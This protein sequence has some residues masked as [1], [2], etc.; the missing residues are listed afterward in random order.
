MRLSPIAH[1]PDD[2]R[3]PL[4]A[5]QIGAICERA[6]GGSATVESADELDGGEFNATYRL[7]LAGREVPAGSPPA[8]VILRAAPTPA[9]DLAWHEVA[10]MRRELAVAPFFAPVAARMPRTLYSDLTHQIVPRDYVLQSV[11]PGVC[12]RDLRATLPAEE[13]EALWREL[14]GIA[15]TIHSVEGDA[16]GMPVSGGSYPTWS[17]AIIAWLDLT[18][19]DLARAGCDTALVLALRE[20]AAERAELL[21]EVR[22]PRL[23]HG[24]LW[25]FN[26]LIERG[27]DGADG[28]DSWDS[29]DG[30]HISAVLDADRATWGDPLY[31][32]TFHLLPRKASERV[33]SVFWEAYGRP[34][35][36]PGLRFRERLY[37]ALHTANV[38][39]EVARRGRG[40]Q[41]VE[42]AAALRTTAERALA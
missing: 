32:W 11:M 16:F 36:T 2:L 33:R 39:A 23:L 15:R 22:V 31:E 42:I 7:H 26:V 29:A 8:S 6:F 25:P 38:L 37:D 14:A 1:G 21:D 18:A 13:D 3:E 17:A 9:R 30:P 41:V 20:R 35:E 10:L 24:D 4:T 28:A 40:D 5:D 12:W 27:A 19:H 34:P